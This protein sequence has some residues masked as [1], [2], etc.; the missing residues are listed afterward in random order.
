VAR[1]NWDLLLVSLIDAHIA[2]RQGSP[3][4]LRNAAKIMMAT[5]DK[6]SLLAV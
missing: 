3:S 5:Q 1:E 4:P 2:N 6:Q